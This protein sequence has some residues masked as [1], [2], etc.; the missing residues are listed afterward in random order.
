MELVKDLNKEMMD[1]KSKTSIHI[2][3]E[4]ADLVGIGQEKFL[5]GFRGSIYII[6]N[7]ANLSKKNFNLV[8]EL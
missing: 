4:H 7:V 2:V 6:V 1:R 3:L 5:N 8:G